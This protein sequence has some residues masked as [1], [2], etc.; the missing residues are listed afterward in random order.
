LLTASLALAS[1]LPKTDVRGSYV[2]ARTAD[3]YTGPCFANGEVGV[4][5]DL[6]VLGWK[7]DKGTWQGTQLDGLAVV[8]AVSASGT[9]GDVNRT[10]Y[11]VKAVLIVDDRANPEQRLALKGFAQQMAGDLLRDIV[12]IDASPISLT[13]D[14]NNPHHAAA[15]LTAGPLAQITTR[16]I[17][18][19]D[20]ICHN[21]EVWY[22]PLSKVDHAMPAFTLASTFKGE[23]L[24]TVW[25]SPGKRSAFVA[26]FHYAN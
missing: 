12:R 6:A 5:G 18:G 15:S 21:E 10:V 2:E 26:S 8:A 7:I 3:V 9:L 20:D 25:S 23:G 14:G 11:P 13:L 19:G 22:P 24:G 17:E 16:A 4:S 1:G